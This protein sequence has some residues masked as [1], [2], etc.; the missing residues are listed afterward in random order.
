MESPALLIDGVHHAFGPTEVLH[1]VS[2][3]LRRGEVIAL[4]GPSGCGK[5][6][7]MHL[8][9]GL[10]APQRGQVLRGAARAAVMF[11]QPR[12]LPWKRAVD[13][14]ALG[15][16][17]QGRRSDAARQ[18]ALAVGLEL[19][20]DA[21]ALQ[22]YPD[23]L[24]GGM[25]SRVALARALVLQPQLLL[26][27][28]PFSALDIGLRAQLHRLLLRQRARTDLSVLMIT[29]DVQEAVRLA[30]EVLV[31]AGQPG[32]IVHRRTIEGPAE[33]RDDRAVLLEAGRLLE[34]PAVAQAFG[35]DALRAGGEPR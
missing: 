22:A 26:M 15:L 16:R 4:L 33:A 23:Q 29:H 32:R 2:L 30:D 10:L 1:D 28:E 25:Q 35:L 12:L 20:L 18:Q 17:A 7:L 11:Q 6:T 13:N 8:A 19:G 31:M 5:T 27:D 24:S 21:E 9:A 34:E 14:I 3:S